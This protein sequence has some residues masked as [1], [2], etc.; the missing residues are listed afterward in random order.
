MTAKTASPDGRSDVAHYMLGRPQY[1]STVQMLVV[2]TPTGDVY[3]KRI[4][5]TVPTTAHEDWIDRM[6]ELGMIERI[7]EAA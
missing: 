3:L 7:E 5:A 1:R 4:G 2:A 6:L